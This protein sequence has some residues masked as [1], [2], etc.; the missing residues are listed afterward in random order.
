MYASIRCCFCNNDLSPIER[1][2]PNR[3]KITMA[4]SISNEDLKIWQKQV[5]AEECTI[6]IA[7]ETIEG[8]GAVPPKNPTRVLRKGSFITITGWSNSEYFVRLGE[9]QEEKVSIL[10]SELP[11]IKVE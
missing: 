9:N 7:T 5:V 6:T 8:R 3:R 10:K 4:H 1:S 11:K 2:E